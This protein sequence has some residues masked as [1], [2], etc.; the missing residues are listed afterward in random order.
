MLFRSDWERIAALLTAVTTIN[1]HSVGWLMDADGNL[2]W[3]VAHPE[4]VGRSAL[5]ADRG[6]SDCHAAF[7]LEA[8]MLEGGSGVGEVQVSDSPRRLVAWAAVS[9]LGHRWALAGSAPHDDVVASGRRNRAAVFVAKGFLVAV[10]VILA[11]LLDVQ[12][13]RRNREL[14]ESELAVQET[15]MS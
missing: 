12:N 3:S 1:R 4:M 11:I 6:C 8:R 7:S 15:T 14:R 9:V 5:H 13:R 2:L 10:H